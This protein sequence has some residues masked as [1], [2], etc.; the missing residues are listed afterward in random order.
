M[1]HGSGG[2]QNRVYSNDKPSA[3]VKVVCVRCGHWWYVSS[4]DEYARQVAILWQPWETS[5]S[6]EQK[7]QVKQRN[8]PAKLE[9]AV[10]KEGCLRSLCDPCRLELTL[11]LYYGEPLDEAS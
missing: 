4:V 8:D 6:P 3:L 7:E 9:E 11:K 10:K 1:G 5:M 2:N